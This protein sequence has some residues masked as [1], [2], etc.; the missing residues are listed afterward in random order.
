MKK[1]VLTFIGLGW[2]L[3][4]S[5]QEDL[6]E[7]QWISR[8]SISS[9]ATGA[10]YD[11]QVAR[12]AE[13][14]QPGESCA[15]IYVLDGEENIDLVTDQCKKLSMSHG[16]AN[17]LVVSIGYGRDRNMDYTPT[18][19][20]STTGGGPEFLKFIRDELIPKMEQEF[21]ADTARSQRAI[22]GHSFGGLFGAY[23]FVADNSVFGNYLLLSP[24]LWFDDDIILLMEA[25][26]R[27]NLQ[28]ENELIYLGIGAMENV[29]K[30]QAPVESFYQTLSQY[31]GNARIMK[32]LE[33]DLGH[34]GSKNPNIKKA[35]NF[36]FENR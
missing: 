27:S 4:A 9:S 20:S 34:V 28:K 26:H 22:L 30:M 7:P 5:C 19:T 23:A 15:A 13:S 32:N 2:L 8:F 31:Y 17:V 21:G 14:L 12:P 18:K 36:Y 3:F 11:I 33:P 1:R 25:G 10:T 16:G 24:S 35:L 6:P 29:G